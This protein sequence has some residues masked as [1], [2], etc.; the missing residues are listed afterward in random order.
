MINFFR[1]FST[2]VDYGEREL[3]AGQQ[4]SLLQVCEYQDYLSG[5]LPFYPVMNHNRLTDPSSVTEIL[6]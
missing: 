1:L 6:P 3:C 5:E 2:R 4:P